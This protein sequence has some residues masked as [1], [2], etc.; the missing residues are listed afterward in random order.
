MPTLITKAFTALA[1]QVRKTTASRGSISEYSYGA[2]HVYGQPQS[3]N[4]DGLGVIT[5]E[6]KREIAIKTPTLAA[7]INAIIDYAS[8]VELLIR[9]IDPSKPAN[10]AKVQY[11]RDFF[12]KP[13]ERDT[14]KHFLEALYR[15]LIVLG[16]G[17]IEIERSASGKAA[18]LRVLDAGK[19]KVDYDQHGTVLG[20]NMLNALG[21]P[22]IG[23]DGVH[24]WLP[25]DIIF[26]KRDAKSSSV[27]PESRLDQLFVC[28]VIESLMLAFIGEKFTSSN[29][30]YGVYNLGDIS[31]EELKIAVSQWNE[32]AKSN[33]RILLT[34]SRGTATWTEFGYALKDLE[35]KSLLA[36]VRSKIMSITG[37]TDNELGNSGDVS[38]ANGFNLSYTFKKRGVE[39]VLRETV[40]TLTRRFIWDELLFNELEAYFDEI[41]TRDALLQGQ[42]D[43]LNFKNGFE[44]INSILNRR[45]MPSIPGGEKH[46]VTIGAMILPVDMIEAYAKAQLESLK[47]PPQPDQAP[48]TNPNGMNLR[49]DTPQSPR[50]AVQKL[51]NTGYRKEDT[52][53]EPKATKSSG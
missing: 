20:Y 37:V 9:N 39:P 28:A 18:N 44:S 21:F 34:G 32:Q 26:F 24:T 13:N 52:H 41:D 1:E 35:A 3:R 23:E 14:G 10:K 29:V 25:K 16:Y 7:C 11:V 19:L 22:I 33:H 4:V 6:R 40:T 51:R 38:K 50:G 43:E 47:P 49:T 53:N 27:Y 48:G 5:P 46:Y 36:D 45:G 31:E 8:P 30:P 12:N 15:D 2:P 17:A 42:I